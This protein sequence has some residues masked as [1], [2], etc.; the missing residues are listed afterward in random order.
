MSFSALMG[1]IPRE[2]REKWIENAM[3]YSPEDLAAGLDYLM[4]KKTDLT[5]PIPNA[6]FIFG[7][8]DKIVPLAQKKLFSQQTAKICEDSGHWLPGYFGND[9]T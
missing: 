9:F 2:K 5:A 8:Q 7:G 1:D 6:E 3:R 4:Q